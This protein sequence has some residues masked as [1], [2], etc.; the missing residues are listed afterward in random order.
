MS[1][2]ASIVLSKNLKT[3]YLDIFLLDHLDP[4]SNREE[5]AFTLMQLK[6]SGK[7]KHI[8][9]ANFSVFQHQ[10]LSAYLKTPIVTNPIELNLLNT[11]SLDNGPDRLYQAKVYAAARVLAACQRQNC[12]RT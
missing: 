2:G 7:V 5:T 9:I 12:I 6:D 8:G 1:S 11:A 10:L 4:V 3:D